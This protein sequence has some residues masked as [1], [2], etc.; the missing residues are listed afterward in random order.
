M[1][2]KQIKEDEKSYCL[3]INNVEVEFR[4]DTVKGYYRGGESWWEYV[5]YYPDLD[6]YAFL[7]CYVSGDLITV[8]GLYADRPGKR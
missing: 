3:N 4:K 7:S 1:L 6:M 2:K 5:G 8:F